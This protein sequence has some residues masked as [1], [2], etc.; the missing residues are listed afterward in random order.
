MKRIIS[1]ILLSLL[2]F[3]L[4]AQ[5]EAPE[6][7]SFEEVAVALDSIRSGYDNEWTE[8]SME[9]KLQFDGLP[10][11]PT[12][13]IYMKRGESVIMSARASIFGE[14]AR[15]ELNKDSLTIIN[16]HSKTYNS[17]P[18]GAYLSRYPGAIA[19]IQDIL[20]GQ[21]AF[22]G[23]GRITEELASLSAW[24]PVPA[25][26]AA[27]IYPGE[28]LQ[29]P[30]A[31]YGFLMDPSDWHLQSFAIALQKAQAYIETG[32]L[33]GGSGWTL[34]LKITLREHPYQGAL[35]LSYPE[36]SPT[37]LEFTKVTDK[38]RKV[39]IRKLLKF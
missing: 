23:H 30:G 29:F 20:L 24:L 34:T 12:V 6:Q 15:I 1:I 11:R 7:L 22:P 8:L 28:T 10:L 14:V 26:E 35:E 17:Q 36:Y 33:Y 31:D 27:L 21:V 18:L 3:L 2:P 16:K 9:G 38:Y 5:D 13:K 32:Y 37:P 19:D 4:L 25:Q 39:D